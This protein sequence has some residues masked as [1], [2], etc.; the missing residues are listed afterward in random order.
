MFRRFPRIWEVGG[1]EWIEGILLFWYSQRAL[2]T[3]GP[4]PCR[5][6]AGAK[7]SI[8]INHGLLM[9]PRQQAHLFKMW[10]IKSL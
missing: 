9:S 7:E 2:L 10:S 3:P 4:G 6:R 1:E 8:S 5:E